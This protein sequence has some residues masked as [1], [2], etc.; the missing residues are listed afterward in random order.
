MV[1]PCSAVEPTID[2]YQ[3]CPLQVILDSFDHI[4]YACHNNIGT[5]SDIIS[6]ITFLFICVLSM[7]A[8]IIQ[9]HTLLS[10]AIFVYGMM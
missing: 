9:Q 8:E 1:S 6:R 3:M 5:P 4:P 10:R 7:L 2:E